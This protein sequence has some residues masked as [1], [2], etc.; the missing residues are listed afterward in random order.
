MYC[1]TAARVISGD[2]TVS[3]HKNSHKSSGREREE[4]PT[5]CCSPCRLLGKWNAVVWA[6][7]WFWVS[8]DTDDRGDSRGEVAELR[9]PRLSG[10][11]NFSVL[12]W[13]YQ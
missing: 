9:A 13:I 5:T 12:S 7:F 2:S 1:R 3:L 11:D 10:G 8:M 4:W 6:R